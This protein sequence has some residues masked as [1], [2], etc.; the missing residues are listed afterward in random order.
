MTQARSQTMIPALWGSLWCS[1]QL[2]EVLEGVCREWHCARHH[3]PNPDGSE[4]PATILGWRQNQEACVS[5]A[6]NI[7]AQ[8]CLWKINKEQ[9]TPKYNM[10]L[11]RLNECSPKGPL[12]QYRSFRR[13]FSRSVL[14]DIRKSV[15]HD[16]HRVAT[17]FL[18]SRMTFDLRGSGKHD[19]SGPTQ[20][21]EKHENH[22]Y[23]WLSINN[24]QILTDFPILCFFVFGLLTEIEE[25]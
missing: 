21:T 12:R 17:V 5:T 9:D 23:L 8:A 13:C 25:Q 19:M 20:R 14:L 6:R 7:R 11:E 15:L 3:S 4:I 24:H 18:F 16:C 10:N 2:Q 22:Q 1:R